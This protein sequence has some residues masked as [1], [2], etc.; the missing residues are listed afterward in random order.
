MKP[1]LRPLAALPHS[2]ASIST[3]SRDGSR[4]LAMIAV[5]RPVYPPPTTHRSQLSVRT[6]V[7]FESGS[8][9]SSYQYGY[10]SASA[11][12]SR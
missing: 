4:S 1:P 6:S 12:A 2:W 7:G 10:W 11:I 5:Q 8:S 9:T 3:T